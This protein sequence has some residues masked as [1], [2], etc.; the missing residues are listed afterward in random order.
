MIWWTR[1]DISSSSSSSTF[2]PLSHHHRLPLSRNNP[3]SHSQLI[4]NSSSQQQ[5]RN[6]PI[7][8]LCK[9]P[10]WF[11]VVVTVV[12]ASRIDTKAFI[13]RSIMLGFKMND[14]HNNKRR[15]RVWMRDGHYLLMPITAPPRVDGGDIVTVS[16]ELEEYFCRQSK[17]LNMFAGYL[18]GAN[19]NNIPF[20]GIWT[21]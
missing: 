13:V 18:E 6:T 16:V 19:R 21:H 9:S 15:E 7:R 4:C 11:F 14:G 17:T 12:E 20:P 2:A 10:N 3:A 8:Q 5:Q 1:S